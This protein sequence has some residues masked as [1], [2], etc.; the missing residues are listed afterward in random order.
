MNQTLKKKLSALLGI[1]INL[2]TIV[3]VC[4]SAAFLMQKT[5]YSYIFVSGG[6]MTPTLLGDTSIPY[7]SNG[8]MHEGGTVHFGVT[9]ES[10]KAKKNINRFDIVTTYFPDDY[11]DGK[12]IPGSDYKI[13][14]VIALPGDT[15][16]IEESVLFV[17]KEGTYHKI[18]G[19]FEVF[20]GDNITAKDVSERT[21]GENEYW[22]MGD[23]RSA[24]G[25]RDCASFNK[26]IKFNQI[27]GVVVTFEGTAE[28]FVHY[29]CKKH[30]HE[31][32]EEDYLSGKI[33]TC[34]ICGSNIIKGK[35]DIRNRVYSYPNIV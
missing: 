24:G 21:L 12:L 18:E 9:D 34:P 1:A 25:S 8:K 30:S 31:I 15:F 3:V 7:Y 16:K 13:K 35:G 20:N 29:L 32:N 19:N 11:V 26:P 2:A 27:I 17:K 5:Y 4:V 28:Y 6:S 33:T 22:L 14:R 10:D 23:N